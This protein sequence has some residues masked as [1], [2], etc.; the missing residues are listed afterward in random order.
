MINSFDLPEPMPIGTSD[1]HLSTLTAKTRMMDLRAEAKSAR[2]VR[3]YRRAHPELSTRYRM[4]AALRR[5]ADRLAPPAS[6][7][8]PRPRIVRP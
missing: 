4:A 1:P 8:S 2:L 3:E 5:L 6:A 7:A